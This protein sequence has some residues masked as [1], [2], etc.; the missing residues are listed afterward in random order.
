LFLSL[1]V[2]FGHTTRQMPDS[3]LIQPRSHSQYGQRQK[4]DT[5]DTIVGSSRPSVGQVSIVCCF[6]D[7]VLC[8]CTEC[9]FLCSWTM[10][11]RP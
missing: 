3:T 8:F 10:Y 9:C 4:S 11:Q 1:V 6:H 2:A 5:S 7:S